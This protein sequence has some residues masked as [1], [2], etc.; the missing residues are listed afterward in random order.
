MTTEFKLIVA[1]SRTFN[2]YELLSRVIFAYAEDT[3]LEVSIVSGMAK[4]ADMLAARFA[5]EHNIKLYKFH[6]DWNIHGKRAGFLRNEDMGKFAD[7]LLALWDGESR[8]TEHMIKFMRSLNK[9][10]T[11][12]KF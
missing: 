8:G 5:Q 1:G 7:G 6:A 2:D 11:L 4:G 12:F 9:P 3:D 10:V